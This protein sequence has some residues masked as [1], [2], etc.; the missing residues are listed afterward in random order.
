LPLPAYVTLKIYEIH[1]ELID[2][3]VDRH[4]EAGIYNF[5]WNSGNVKPGI[6]LLQMNADGVKKTK[7]LVITI[8]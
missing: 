7:K 3:V 4:F 5:P 6:Y 2:V 1:G 8:Q